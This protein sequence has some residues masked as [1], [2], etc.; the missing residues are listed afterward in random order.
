MALAPKA[1][2]DALGHQEAGGEVVGDSL[3]LIMSGAA[4]PIVVQEV[5]G[6]VVENVLELVHHAEA[7]AEPVLAAAQADDP[8][9]AVPMGCA[10]DGQP[11][12][13]LDSDA[14]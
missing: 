11:V 8:V 5:L 4:G 13:A 2:D 6:G 12:L 9:V 10:G 7:L 1:L 14:W 3:G